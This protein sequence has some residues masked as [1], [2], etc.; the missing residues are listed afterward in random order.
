VSDAR[1][2]SMSRKRKERRH[3][4]VMVQISPHHA[5][6]AWRRKPP[7]RGINGSICE[8]GILEHKLER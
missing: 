1:P 8:G 6:A 3:Q 5:N 4:V 2:R 7:R